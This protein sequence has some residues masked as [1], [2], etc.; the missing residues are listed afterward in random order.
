MIVDSH[1]H[2]G[3]TVSAPC[4]DKSTEAALALMDHLGIDK[5]ISAN[6]PLIA[7][8]LQKGFD[9]AVEAYRLSRGRILSF[10]VFHPMYIEEDLNWVRRCL[11]HE[12]FVGIKI[13]P[14]RAEFYPDDERW[15]PV[16]RVASELQVPILA[17]TWWI[18]DYNPGQRFCTPDR[19]EHYV[20]AYP[21]VMLI[22]GHAGG[23]YEGH[24]SAARLAR[25]YPN[26]FMD[27]S[28]DSYS[29]GLVEW[30]VQHAGADRVL[31]GSDVT[32]IDVRTTMGRVLD[33]EISA[34]DKALILGQNA[35]RLFGLKQREYGGWEDS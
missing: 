9:D 20:R 10:A 35:V 14:R 28:G 26:V 3:M 22:L 25:K 8:R 7:G 1:I 32:L 6:H 16:W 11:E 30:F 34:Q 23:R 2:L 33:A 15:D 19:F 17:H 5:A 18:S 12:A 27:L 13:H 24:L 21:G 29:F 31:F 4:V